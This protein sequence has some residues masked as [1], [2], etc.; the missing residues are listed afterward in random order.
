MEVGMKIKKTLTSKAIA[1]NRANSRKSCGPKNTDAIKHNA[2]KHGL[3]AKSLLFESEEE[4]HLFEGFVE[5]LANEENA[6]GV[7]HLALAEDTAECIWKLRRTAGW[8][9]RELVNGRKAA[10]AV[11]QT[12]AENDGYEQLQLFNDEGTKAAQRG[13]DCH[14]LAIRT[15]AR[16]VEDEGNSIAGPSSKTGHVQIEAKLTS[17]LDTIMRYQTS[18]RRDL[19]RAIAALREMRRDRELEVQS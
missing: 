8:D 12:I 2:V 4:R 1:A 5:E 17:S 13:W 6:C 9:L 15:G 14:E 16:D 10:R 7:L 18:V 3:L 19:Y 11:L